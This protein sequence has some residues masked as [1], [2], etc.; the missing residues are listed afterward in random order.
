MDNKIKELKAL[1]EKGNTYFILGLIYLVA[2][3]VVSVVVNKKEKRLR[4]KN[5]YRSRKTTYNKDRKEVL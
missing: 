4:K 3:V 5:W 2:Y 1:K